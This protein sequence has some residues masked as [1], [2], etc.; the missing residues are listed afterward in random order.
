MISRPCTLRHSLTPGVRSGSL[1]TLARVPALS[2]LACAC[3]CLP[4]RNPHPA[5]QPIKREAPFSS[6]ISF[7]PPRLALRERQQAASHV[8][9]PHSPAALCAVP[10]LLACHRACPCTALVLIL[11]FHRACARA[12]LHYKRTAWP[13]A[14]TTTQIS[15]CCHSTPPTP[16][17]RQYHLRLRNSSAQLLCITFVCSWW[18]FYCPVTHERS[19]LVPTPWPHLH[20]LPARHKYAAAVGRCPPFDSY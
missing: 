6:S 10:I 18:A 15:P 3:A 13:S 16:S 7:R 19:L 14:T 20:T 12:G 11:A 2:V 8:R 5:C 4:Q 1:C 9:P 17:P